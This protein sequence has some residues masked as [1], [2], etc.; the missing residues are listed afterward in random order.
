[1]DRFIAV[2]ISGMAYTLR[3]LKSN[4][5]RFIAS[6]SMIS[7]STY[8]GFKI[9][10]GQIYSNGGNLEVLRV[11]LFKIQYGQIYSL[12]TPISSGFQKHLKSNMD[13]FIA[14]L[15]FYLPKDL[16][17][18]KIQYGQI[19]SKHRALRNWNLAN[20]KSNMDRFIDENSNIF[21]PE[22]NSFKIQYGQIYR[23]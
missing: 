9:Q 7:F 23:T 2:K 6:F 19:Y 12:K 17:L 20:L 15:A 22:I 5:D 13:R 21:F 14:L 3:D 18:F 4:M 10:Y 16:A 1:M 8:I 11:L